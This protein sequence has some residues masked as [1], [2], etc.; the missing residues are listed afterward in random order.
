MKADLYDADRFAW[1]EE[2]THLIRLGRLTEIDRTHLL[3]ELEAEMGNEKRELYRRLRVLLTHLLKWQFQ[4]S[5]RSG[6]W[7]G[8]IRT[9]R[10]DIL[11][12]F[13]NSPSLRRYFNDE[14]Q[15]AYPQARELA[16]D[17]TGISE[18]AFP[19]ECPYA[20]EEILDKDFWPN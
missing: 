3:E 4:P 16:A 5:N 18:D 8:T 11:K 12:L 6:S 15:D 2:Q 9:Q 14:C 13:K 1:L 7:K 10:S 19:S 17:E 20:L